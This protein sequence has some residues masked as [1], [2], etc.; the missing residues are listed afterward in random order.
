MTLAW[1]DNYSKRKLKA[2]CKT[3]LGKCGFV[4]YCTITYSFLTA[5]K[6]GIHISVEAYLPKNDNEGWEL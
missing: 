5:F 4:V 3:V 1:F 6:K 2:P